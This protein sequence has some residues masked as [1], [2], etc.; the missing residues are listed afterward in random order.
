MDKSYNDIKAQEQ[1]VIATAT[2]LGRYRDN[3]RRCVDIQRIAQITRNTLC[4]H[5]IGFFGYDPNE[6][7][8]HK[9][10]ERPKEEPER[11]SLEEK[12]AAGVEMQTP[13]PTQKAES[14]MALVDWMAA[15][16]ANRKKIADI[17]RHQFIKKMY[18]EL[19]GDMTFCK[20][21]GWDIY[22]FPRMIRDAVNRCLP[23]PKQLTIPFV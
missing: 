16:E 23:A 3:K 20:M 13:T 6:K 18:A 5:G 21:E 7:K 10:I 14:R 4:Q 2:E 17:A 9:M 8:P 15:D 19:L 12:R 1:R 11:P 22:E